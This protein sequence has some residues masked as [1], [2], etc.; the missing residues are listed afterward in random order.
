VLLSAIESA[1]AE[2]AAVAIAVLAPGLHEFPEI[3][4]ALFE[5]LEDDALGSGAALALARHPD[6]AITRRLE[7]SG[8][9][10]SPG[11]QRARMALEVSRE[12]ALTAAEPDQAAGVEQ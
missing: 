8:A 11:A 1:P 7:Q 4:D 3:T 10:K 9:G 6:P 5:L 2:N 12:A